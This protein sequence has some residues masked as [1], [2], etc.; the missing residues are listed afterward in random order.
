MDKVEGACGQM[1]SHGRAKNTYF[2]VDLTILRNHK[3]WSGKGNDAQDRIKMETK[4]KVLTGAGR[5]LK[6]KGLRTIQ[7][8]NDEKAH[9]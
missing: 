7:E 6:D 2:E 3:W 9:R 4:R 5:S 8:T 1:K